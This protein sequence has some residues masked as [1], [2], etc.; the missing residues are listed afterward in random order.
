M[1][2]EIAFEQGEVSAAASVERAITN[3]LE[4]TSR[5]LGMIIQ[6]HEVRSTSILVSTDYLRL[7]SSILAALKP[8]PDA[9]RAVSTALANLESEAA[10]EISERKAPLLLEASPG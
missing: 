8:Y 10:K 3:S 7:R 2:S 5:L 9:A 6:H 1:L 4:L